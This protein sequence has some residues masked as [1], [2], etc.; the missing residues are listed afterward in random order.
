MSV[1]ANFIQ[2][3]SHQFRTPLAVINTNVDLLERKL[4]NDHYLSYL[5]SIRSQVHTITD[6]IES[7]GLMIEL[8]N[9]AKDMR[10]SVDLND[11]AHDMVSVKK[12]IAQRKNVE[13]ELVTANG[14]PYVKGHLGYLR[15]A[16][17]HLLDNA[18]AAVPEH[19]QVHLQVYSAPNM[20]VVEV[21]DNGSGIPTEHL[22]KIFTRFYRG[23]SAGTTRGLGLGLS[24]VQKIMDLHHAHIEV[25][26]ELHRGSI[27]RMVFP[28]DFKNEH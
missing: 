16:L 19:G 18:I 7:L 24:I 5:D 10:A 20:V 28:K 1:M 27:F 17:G 12:P 4:N 8:D 2:D 13:I 3:P 22:K 15:Q 9:D 14:A 23:D 26:S 21:E 25:E 11:I 6:L